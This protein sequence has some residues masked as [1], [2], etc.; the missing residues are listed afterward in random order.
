MPHFIMICNAC[1]TMKAAPHRP[2][3]LNPISHKLYMKQSYSGEI[4]TTKHNLNLCDDCVASFEVWKEHRK[5][6][7]KE[8]P[9][10]QK[11]GGV[12]EGYKAPS[13]KYKHKLSI[14]QQMAQHEG[15]PWASDTPLWKNLKEEKE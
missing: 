12:G 9:D 7:K 10:L 14:A 13:Y 5:R 3:E 4:W 2:D 15:L 6:F 8:A 11:G 1:G